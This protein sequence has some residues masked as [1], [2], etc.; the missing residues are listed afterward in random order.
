M[1]PVRGESGGAEARWPMAGAILS[2]MLLTALLPDEV[3]LG[4]AWALP[5]IEGVLLVAVIA[6]DPGSIARRSR[7]LRTLS[8]ALVSILVLGALWSTCY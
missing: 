4:P 6:A 3:R 7:W 8:I 5:L 2:A 1:G